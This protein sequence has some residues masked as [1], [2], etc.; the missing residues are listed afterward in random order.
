MY[1]VEGDV[2]MRYLME[3]DGPEAGPV[4]LLALGHH[5][6]QLGHPPSLSFL[7]H[8]DLMGHHVCVPL[9]FFSLTH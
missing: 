5:A 4:L 7:L 8:N 6:G 1:P 3:Q 9:D 2:D